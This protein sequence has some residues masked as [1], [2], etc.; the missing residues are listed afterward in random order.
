MQ[1]L[2]RVGFIKEHKSRLG[3]KGFNLYKYRCSFGFFLFSTSMASTSNRLTVVFQSLYPPDSNEITHFLSETEISISEDL[4]NTEIRFDDEYLKRFIIPKSRQVWEVENIAIKD[5]H[6]V[7]A[8]LALMLLVKYP[9]AAIHLYVNNNEPQQE[10]EDSIK[11]PVYETHDIFTLN[12][13]S[14]A[15]NNPPD[16]I[17]I[18]DVLKDFEKYI[19]ERHAFTKEKTREKLFTCKKCQRSLSVVDSSVAVRTLDEVVS[20]TTACDFCDTPKNEPSSLM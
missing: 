16:N 12:R 9:N 10:R 2:V 1:K 20:V 13:G 6:N 18:H 4:C 3:T 14:S 15:F 8:A 17:N 5:S 11:T 7:T 19:E